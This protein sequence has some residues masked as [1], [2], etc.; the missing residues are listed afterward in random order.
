MRDRLVVLILN[1]TREREYIDRRISGF[2][3]PNESISILLKG[4]PAHLSTAADS[5]AARMN[6]STTSDNPNKND[7][8]SDALLA[9][10][11]A[12]TDLASLSRVYH[13]L[14]QVDSV[15]T[16]TTVLDKLLPRLLK[17]IGDNHKQQLQ[18]QPP[19]QQELASLLQQIHTKLVEILSHTMKRVRED[20]KCKLPCRSILELFVVRG[21]AKNDEDDSTDAAT[22]GIG[23]LPSSNLSQCDALTINLALPFLAIGIPRLTAATDELEEVLPLLLVLTAATRPGQLQSAS[24]AQ[25]HYQMAH[26]LLKAVE[27][28]VMETQQQPAYNNNQK[29]PPTRQQRDYC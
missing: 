14:A 16:L 15:A 11:T 6:T 28:L 4:P 17:R 25:Q 20:A 2:E 10:Q 1:D 19:Q 9:V 29:E 5:S 21:D 8:Q 22:E 24:H 18:Q 23:P 3:C 7:E 27:L 12:K 13:R 26:L